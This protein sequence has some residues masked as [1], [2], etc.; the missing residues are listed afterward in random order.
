MLRSVNS[1]EARIALNM[2]PKLG[3]VRFGR[4]L[5]VFG[6]PERIFAA[7]NH[8]LRNID[9]IGKEVADSISTW[10]S[11]VNLEDELRR[12]Q[13]FGAVVLTPDSSEYPRLLREIHDPPIV[14]YVWGTL[15]ERD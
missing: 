6:S 11:V 3:P 10:E 4:L 2:V 9:G 7:K 5:D 12:I 8:E 13:E 14:L 1:T 15:H